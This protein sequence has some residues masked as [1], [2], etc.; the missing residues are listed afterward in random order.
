VFDT[1][2]GRESTV[3]DFAQR[4]SSILQ[5][6]LEFA[7][8]TAKSHIQNYM[9]QLQ[10]NGDNIYDHSGVSMVLE[11]VMKYSKPRAEAESLDSASLTR[12]PDCV[13]KDFSSFVG[14]M[15]E[16]YNYVGIMQ[17]LCKNSND[18]YIVRNLSKEMRTFCAA[19]NEKQL[20]T[21]MLKA[22]AFLILKRMNDISDEAIQQVFIEMNRNLI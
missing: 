6:A 10:Q 1:L 21:A 12:R 3:N 4:C 14:Q 15:N 18:L 5:E 20:K 7:P 9:L 22:A 16:K 19:R 2:E 8:I 17:G 11:C 13:K